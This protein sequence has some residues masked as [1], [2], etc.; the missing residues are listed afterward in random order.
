MAAFADLLGGQLLT[1]DGPRPTRE[2][3]AGKRH[4]LL[5]FSGH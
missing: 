4:V 3:L 1:K 5:Y 2:V